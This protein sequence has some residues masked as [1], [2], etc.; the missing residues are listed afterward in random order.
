MVELCTEDE[1]FSSLE[2]VLDNLVSL[3]GLLRRA[4][5]LKHL[6]YLRYS[7]DVLVLLVEGLSMLEFFWI[8]TDQ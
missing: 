2:N 7:C 8:I 1:L 6:E 3:F 4:L 5:Q